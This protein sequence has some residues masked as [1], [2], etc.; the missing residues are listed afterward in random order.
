[1]D[2]A[3]GGVGGKLGDRKRGTV[4]LGA[5]GL[6]SVLHCVP[7]PPAHI[8]GVTALHDDGENAVKERKRLCC[9]IGRGRVTAG[10]QAGEELFGTRFVT[11]TVDRALAR[12]GIGKGKIDDKKFVSV[13][14]H[15]HGVKRAVCQ[16]QDV[17]FLR[18]E[19]QTVVEGIMA[20]ALQNK[21]QTVT[22]ASLG[23]HG[24]DAAGKR[25]SVYLGLFA[26]KEFGYCN[27]FFGHKI[28]S[29]AILL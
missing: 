15:V 7:C 27:I 19:G 26:N 9:R 16:V 2:L 23:A 28:T 3:H 8:M 25:A 1:M 20:S 22:R 10:A 12:L 11:G 14:V 4:T 29:D 6:G 18:R 17:V 5:Y 13:T 21:D 24:D